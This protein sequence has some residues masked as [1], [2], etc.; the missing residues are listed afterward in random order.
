MKTLSLLFLFSLGLVLA[1]SLP[2]EA[3]D[4][5]S[6]ITML[7]Q[8][9][10]ETMRLTKRADDHRVS[11]VMGGAHTIPGVLVGAR[12]FVVTPFAAVPVATTSK[13]HLAGGKLV[14]AKVVFSDAELGIAVY[15]MGAGAPKGLSGLPIR[16][17][18][19]FARG[20]LV[21]AG[22]ATP[23]LALIDGVDRA[24]GRIRAGQT[25]PG[26][27][28]LDSRGRVAGLGGA[29]G[30]ANCSACHQNNLHVGVGQWSG[31]KTYRFPWRGHAYPSNHKSQGFLHE[32]GYALKDGH[33]ILGVAQPPASTVPYHA[34]GALAD[35][36][37][38]WYGLG[39]P[40]T[41]AHPGH[42]VAGPVIARVIDDLE[43]HGRVRY[44]YLGVVPG[45][46]T[47][48]DKQRGVTLDTVLE[49]SPAA[50]AGVKAGDVLIAVNGHACRDPGTLGRVLVQKQ[51]G[52]RTRLEIAGRDAELEVVLG[53][54]GEARASQVKPADLG[55]TVVELGEGLRTFLAVEDGAVGVVV[56]KVEQGS[57]AQRAGLKRGDL[58]VAGG[59][60]PV[61]DVAEFEAVV[62][63]AN[64]MVK[65]TVRGRNGGKSRRLVL[66]LPGANRRAR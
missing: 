61:R 13:V 18:W 2:G 50:S 40:S 41:Q 51:P 48:V 24:S 20:Q 62:A 38:S 3:D 59:G 26:S 58:V 44:A 17:A 53:D 25:P 33:V 37:H 21:V 4:D 11:V 7:E 29:G 12:P 66:G 60:G 43:K 27:L 45:R 42:F 23:A 32:A 34:L 6:G 9:E 31:M 19:D 63:T 30:M 57:A 64:Q 5:S 28:L 22:D 56:T 10:R 47:K 52:E 16:G 54:R 39:T 35:T 49:G 15:E 46:M 55:L 65:L 1:Y 14:E 8:L 36:G